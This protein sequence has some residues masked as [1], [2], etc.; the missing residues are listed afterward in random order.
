MITIQ[1]S[2]DTFTSLLLFPL[3][4]TSESD[5]N[6]HNFCL[7]FCADFS[8]Q[9]L[10]VVGLEGAIE[11][12]QIYTGLKSAGRRLAQ[13]ASVTIRSGR[14]SYITSPSLPPRSVLLCSSLW[15]FSPLFSTSAIKYVF[16]HL[17]AETH[18]GLQTTTR[19]F[20]VNYWQQVNVTLRWS[21][22]EKWLTSA[23]WR[24]YLGRK[25]NISE[26]IP[27]SNLSFLSCLFGF[28]LLRKYLFIPFVISLVFI[29][30]AR[31]NWILK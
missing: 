15:L 28:F 22:A 31:Q 11:M 21:E 30:S 4:P 17:Q 13:C 26:W 20:P 8:D 6:H 10:E 1:A 5:R 7:L 12:G 19:M 23:G 3:F 29:T 2:K 27:L 18:H 14:P 25:K 16:M 9:L 24:P